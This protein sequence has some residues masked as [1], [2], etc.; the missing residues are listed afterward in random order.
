MQYLVR[1]CVWESVSVCVCVCACHLW[2]MTHLNRNMTHSWAIRETWLIHVRHDSCTWDMTYSPETWLIYVRHDSYDSTRDSHSCI[3][4]TAETWLIR[5]PSVRHDSF[6]WDMTHSRETWLIWLYMWL[7]LVHSRHGWDMTHSHETCLI[8]ET[9][10]IH[11][12]TAETWL[13]HMR[14]DSFMKHD[15]FTWHMRHDSF[16]WDM[17]H[18]HETWL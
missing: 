7:T 16:T 11:A 9:W 10:L 8:H 3:Q 1:V 12:K 13:I 5:E 2:D 4:G 18:S 15:S 17:T 6:T 14:H